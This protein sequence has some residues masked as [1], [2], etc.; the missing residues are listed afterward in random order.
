MLHFIL[1]DDNKF[2]LAEMV[3]LTRQWA[4]TYKFEIEISQF[5]S[6]SSLLEQF[7]PERNDI[8]VLDIMM[9]FMDGITLARRLRN[10][11][12][13]FHIIF[14]TSSKD[15]ALT[16]YDVHP[17]GYLLKPLDYDAYS[18]LL[19][20]LMKKIQQHAL[21]VHAAGETY[22]L[23]IAEIAWVEAVNKK[24]V[25]NMTDGRSI[26]AK[27]TMINIQE[28]LLQYPAFFKPHRSYIVNFNQVEHFN[29][30]EIFMKNAQIAIPIARGMEKEFKTQY[31]AFMFS[32]E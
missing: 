12:Q 23:A 29:T 24:L 32:E 25:F 11:R 17:Y 14:L 18:T 5:T 10:I 3:D 9:P 16:A 31:F 30:K 8:V 6:G 1:C 21:V 28:N 4:D 26:A 27:D 2:H 22:K 13:D 7:K 20:S 19:N 15:F